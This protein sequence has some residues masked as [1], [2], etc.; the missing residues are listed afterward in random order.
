MSTRIIKSLVFAFLFFALNSAGL[1]SEFKHELFDQNDG[2]TSS[3]IFSIEQDKHGFLWFGT[4]YDG[5]L[6]YDG[7]NLLSFT[8]DPADP[9][10][11]PHNNAGNLLFNSQDDLWIGS[12]GGGAAVLDY[13]TQSF[14]H[15][16]AT[17]GE[18]SLNARMVQSLFEDTQGNMWLGSYN[19]GLSRYDKASDSFTALNFTRG[20]AKNTDS[21]MLSS[22]RVW[23]ISQTSENV[24]W[25]GT[26]N[27]L[28]RLD[29]RDNV[30]Q[31]FYPNP[32]SQSE[33]SNRIRHVEVV[34]DELMFLGSQNGIYQFNVKEESFYHL[35]V[36]GG[37]SL[38]PIYSIL[39]TSYG[40]YWVSTDF[41]IY[42]FNENTL[43]LRK[44]KLNFDDTC[45]QTL[46]Q[47]RQGTIWLSC[48]GV[49]IYK[50]TKLDIFSTFDNSELSPAFV[51]D[52]SSDDTI[53]V[54]TYQK[55][56][57]KWNP[58]TNSII[59][60]SKK[61]DKL[62]TQDI[63]FLAQNSENEIWFAN[64]QRVFS[65]DASGNSIEFNPSENHQDYLRQIR[66]IQIDSSD[67]LW[68][69]VTSGIFRI[70]TVGKT[71]S[72]YALPESLPQHLRDFG[73]MRMFIDKKQRIWAM[74][75]NQFYGYDERSDSFSLFYYDE[76]EA[77]KASDFNFA[78]AVYQDSQDNV[79]LSNRLGLYK[80][81]IASGQRELVSTYFNELE[82][83]GV[84]FITEDKNA[85]LWLVSP[86][87]VSRLDINS[88][89][90]VH[91]DRRDGLPDTRYYFKPTVRESD[92]SIFLSSRDGM[93]YFTP[94]E[95]QIANADQD[96]RLTNFEVL[97]AMNNFNMSA[98]MK[99]G[100]SLDADQ[101]NIKFDYA[102]LD[103]LNARQ[104]N[105]QY[106]LEGFDIDWID[107]GTS[108]SA[109]YTNLSGGEY[110]FKVRSRLKDKLW[111]K[112]ELAVNL[113]LATPLW[114]QWWMLIVYI[115]LIF[116]LVV[117]YLYRQKQAVLRLEHQ[118]AKKT[119][120][121]ALESSKLADANRIKTQ[122][123][124]NMS[125][126]IRTPLTTVIGQAEAII[127][128]DIEPNNIYKEVEVIH[129]SSI[130]LL[131]LLNDI[132]DLTKIE[133]DKFHLEYSS[134][135]LH[136]L[137]TNVNTMFSMQARVKGLTF[138]MEHNLPLPFMVN[139]DG[140][141]LKQILVNLL[142]NA[143]KFTLQGHVKLKVD[144]VNDKLVFEIQ[145]T[146]IGIDDEQLAQIFDSFTQGDAS[147]RRR[148][149]GSGLG[150][151]LSNQLA[152]LMKGKIDVKSQ[153]HIGS[154]FT[155]SMPMPEKTALAH[156]DNSETL[157]K[158]ELTQPIF[159]G[160]ILLAEDH[161]DNRR[162]IA[163]L[164]SK[165][166]VD[167]ITAVDGFQAVEQ[168]KQY[169]PDLILLDIQMPIMDGLQ[170]FKALRELGCTQPIVALTANAM[171]AE[172]EQYSAL[173][174]DAFVPKPIDREILI[175]T[176]AQYL[177]SNTEESITK[178]SQSLRE[179]DMSDLVLEFTQSLEK[180]W[181]EFEALIQDQNISGIGAQ[182][183][184]LAGAAQ[185][186]GINDV[187]EKAT[188]VE[189]LIKNGASEVSQISKELASLKAVIALYC[190]NDR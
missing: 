159:K 187:S 119:A 97:G 149:G 36:E 34:N 179:V 73:T 151:H 76:S 61:G 156:A 176:L 54:G 69:A 85:N 157:A 141:R 154:T 13:N 74:V 122:F 125:H 57:K 140:L 49:G 66:D 185:L 83:R 2:F 136:G 160:K 92:G 90:T 189:K 15:Y 132:L 80:A 172:V 17:T 163:R 37:Q 120:D 145:D 4:A 113:K 109:T 51:L 188:I 45:S 47:D 84:R 65:L 164:L 88:G 150:L 81:D 42:A 170:A 32:S 129:D 55:G 52:Q 116:L 114:Q 168:Y 9:S 146:G 1:A 72:Y 118:V 64:N 100:I 35:P 183:H 59:S 124:A 46:F 16:S 67:N 6:R 40:E 105:Y 50:I 93:F 137:L 62:A 102:T 44:V 173:G 29:T 11:I 71:Y 31:H 58:E 186:F 18:G 22:D 128:R 95:I 14:K 12:W 82:N 175:S 142:S 143:I 166:G 25:I 30:F 155:F 53:L 167:V 26:N 60:L 158:A 190:D 91:F 24:I 5:I 112:N 7:K 144:I 180:E 38:G 98:L 27:G 77:E 75:E 181:L 39:K 169:Q 94:D 107:A 162:L 165:L 133:E 48:E 19:A 3:I 8:N 123:L 178:A 134:H 126:E 33:E 182:A 152:V 10:S 171:P 78:Y 89:E 23:D 43:R 20:Y 147:I 99:N 111:Y 70:E 104:I 135:D 96:I 161:E 68:I 21:A 131:T 138:L 127:C 101:T 106:K 121:I 184:K 174:F 117:F 115:V 110:I 130:Y 108:N 79:W 63:R 139:I 28:N 41:G 87:G 177:D 153:L 86:V 148:F 103:L 56:L